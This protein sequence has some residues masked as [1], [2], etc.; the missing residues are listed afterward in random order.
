MIDELRAQGNEAYKAGFLEKAK[1]HYV[2]ALRIDS[3]LASAHAYILCSNLS[4]VYAAQSDWLNSLHAAQRCVHVQPDFAKGWSRIGTAHASVGNRA[5]ALYAFK[6]CLGLDPLN[7]TTRDRILSL[8]AE[9]AAAGAA[10]GRA[11]ESNGTTHAGGT[12]GPPHQYEAG[13]AGPGGARGDAV[14]TSQHRPQPRDQPADTGAV[15][16]IGIP[17]LRQSHLTPESVSRGAGSNGALPSAAHATTG[18]FAAPNPKR[19]LPSSGANAEPEAKRPPQGT[20]SAAPHAVAPA[21]AQASEPDIA[22]GNE[23]YKHGDFAAAAAAFSRAI[24]CYSSVNAVPAALLS[25]RS[26]AYAGL[27]K[28]HEA[29]RD[30]DTCIHVK[31]QWSKGYSRRGN[32]LHGLGRLDEAIAAYRKALHMD[33]TNAVVIVSL[34]N[35]IDLRAAERQAAPSAGGAAPAAGAATLRA[36]P[37]HAG[38]MEEL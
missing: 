30:A 15:S 17:P 29:L 19:P 11:T 36:P 4:A 18:A 6:M 35:C 12:S 22:A 24:T 3:N 28:Y 16:G 21:S 31:P 27:Q 5:E 14:S 2:E 1:Q 33:P 7:A 8:E 37:P 10:V 25:N 26:A 13:A 38:S 20:F 34:Q 9:M 23:A 32:A